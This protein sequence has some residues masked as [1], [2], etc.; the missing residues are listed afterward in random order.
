MTSMQQLIDRLRRWLQQRVHRD[1]QD[2]LATLHGRVSERDH[3][4]VDA[5]VERQAGPSHV[6]A[7]AARHDHEHGH[8]DPR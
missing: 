1:E 3:R 5:V 4:A 6:A 7:D 2:A 8:E